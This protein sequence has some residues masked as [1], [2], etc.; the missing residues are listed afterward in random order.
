VAKKVLT[1]VIIA[2]A[3]FYVL[4]APGSAANAVRGAA[5]GLREA[6]DSVAVFFENLFT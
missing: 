3:V 4:S 2:F 1:W 6:G 5:G